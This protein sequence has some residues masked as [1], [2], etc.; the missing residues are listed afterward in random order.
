MLN[1]QSREGEMTYPDGTTKKEVL[2]D[3]GITETALDYMR[4][5][6]WD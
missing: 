5:I 2:A 6:K 3:D 1:K 4:Q